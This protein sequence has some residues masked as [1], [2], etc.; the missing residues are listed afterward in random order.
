VG[1]CVHATEMNCRAVPFDLRIVA[2]IFFLV[3]LDGT[4]TFVLDAIR[5][6]TANPGYSGN[7][8]CILIYFGLM[9]LWPGFRKGALVLLALY[10]LVMAI[11]AAF[12]LFHHKGG[13]FTFLGHRLI[14]VPYRFT[15]LYFGACL[16]LVA[17]EWKVLTRPEVVSL[18]HERDLIAQPNAPAA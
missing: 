8:I 11:V 5:H 1:L 10:S 4:Y 9:R 14:E 18:F 13:V 17:W 16:A 15:P 12:V 6:P 2:W 7:A 3:G